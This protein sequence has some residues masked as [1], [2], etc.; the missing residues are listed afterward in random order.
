[1]HDIYFKEKY[2]KLY[3]T[4]EKGKLEIFEFKGDAGR[5]RNM[6]IKR[7]IPLKINGEIYYDITTPYGYGGP[8][9]EA[10]QNDT[11]SLVKGYYQAFKDYCRENKIVSEFIRFHP[12]FENHKEFSEIYAVKFNRKTIGTKLNAKEDPF[13]YDFKKECR[14]QIRRAI[15]N[16]VTF[17]VVEKSDNLKEFKKLYYQT[18]ER[19][20]A[21]HYYYFDDV[22]FDTIIRD[23]KNEFILV[24]V[25]FDGKMIASKLCFIS[26]QLIHCH[27]SGVLADYFDYSPGYLLEYATAL[28]GRENHYHYIHHGGGRSNDPNDK[29]LQFKKN[30][31]RHTEFEFYRGEKIWDEAIYKALCDLKGLS[32]EN[33]FFPNYRADR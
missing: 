25:F 17:E 8:M 10:D 9:I 4:I 31:G 18:M 26:Q 32:Q 3:E 30:F 16:G 1:M 28:W 22:Y 20:D 33:D 23:F 5:I 24:N 14:R 27:L 13:M 12:I 11:E 6:F 21:S 29:L 2:G 19:N 7:E 15:R